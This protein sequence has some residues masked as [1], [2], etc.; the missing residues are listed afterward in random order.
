MSK[1]VISPVK[2]FAGSVVLKDPLP[3]FVVVRF[4]QTAREAGGKAEDMGAQFL[5]VILDC[6]EKWE[7][8][9]IP[10]NP[11]PET[12]P[13]TPRPPTLRLI[14]WLLNEITAIYKGNEDNDPNE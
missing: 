3:Y 8:Q 4:E 9:N 1:S 2:Y 11:T 14:A 5:P 7:L 6:V 10:E 13:G 12:F